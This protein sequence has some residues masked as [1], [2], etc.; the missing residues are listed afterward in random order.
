MES[1]ISENKNHISDIKSDVNE[2]NTNI[3]D[4]KYDNDTNREDIA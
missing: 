3:R 1:D 4:L 2:I